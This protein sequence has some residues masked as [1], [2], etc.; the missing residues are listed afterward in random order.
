MYSFEA[1]LLEVA[2]GRK[3][4]YHKDKESLVLVEQVWKLWGSSR[5]RDATD[6]HMAGLY[7]NQEMTALSWMSSAASGFTAR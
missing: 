4:I 1:L 7:N 6:P 3:P 5:I 2:C